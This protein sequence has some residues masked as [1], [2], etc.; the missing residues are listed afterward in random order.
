MGGRMSDCFPWYMM[1]TVISSAANKVK[2]W[3]LTHWKRLWCWE[4]LGAGGEGDDRGWDVRM[5]SPTRWTSS[6]SKLQE[7]VMD[8]EAWR[9]AIHGVA[10]W[11]RLSN[12]TELTELRLL[13]KKFAYICYICILQSA[14]L[15]WVDPSLLYEVYAHQVFFIMLW[16]Q[17]IIS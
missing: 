1:T 10:E 14:C 11:T 5:A 13:Q 17:C 4:G 2:L 3:L 6:L 8:R 16:L 7:L 12:W 9:A 15:F